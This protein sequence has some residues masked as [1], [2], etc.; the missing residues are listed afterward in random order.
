MGLWEY[1]FRETKFYRIVQT[2]QSIA[3]GAFGIQSDRI[4]PKTSSRSY[5]QVT[6]TT[7]REISA[8][9]NLGLD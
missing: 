6:Q 1:R 4:Q 5:F 3:K 9:H 8:S 2:L 7:R